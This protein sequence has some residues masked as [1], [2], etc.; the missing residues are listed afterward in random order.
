MKWA[1]DGI[2]FIRATTATQVLENSTTQAC[3][4]ESHG[5]ELQKGPQRMIIQMMPEQQE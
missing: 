2:R 5:A 3:L 4:E 1:S